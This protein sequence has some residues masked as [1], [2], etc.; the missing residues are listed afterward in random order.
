M[1]GVAEGVGITEDFCAATDGRR[2]WAC[3][4]VPAT[5]NGN[6]NQTFTGRD[7]DASPLMVKGYFCGV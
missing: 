5:S 4:A 6:M 3:E 2:Y 1:V 7:A